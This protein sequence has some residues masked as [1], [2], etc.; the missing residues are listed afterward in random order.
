MFSFNFSGFLSHPSPSCAP[1]L[2]RSRSNCKE[3]ACTGLESCLV[4]PF[5]ANQNRR[6]THLVPGYNS[7][8]IHFGQSPRRF[9]RPRAL[10][11]QLPSFH[12]LSL[13]SPATPLLPLR[14]ARGLSQAVRTHLTYRARSRYFRI[15]T[16]VPAIRFYGLTVGPGRSPYVLSS[17]PRCATTS[18]RL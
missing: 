14:A 3:S 13:L 1:E 2:Q 9:Q 11:S 4:P 5:R 7:K 10:H 6:A 15:D 8:P 17:R 18:F 12:S 16:V